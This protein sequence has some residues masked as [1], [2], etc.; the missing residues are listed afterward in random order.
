MGKRLWW[1]C[2]YGKRQLKLRKNI[3][4][5]SLTAGC[6]LLDSTALKSCFILLEFGLACHLGVLLNKPCVGVAKKLF[7]V[8]G[9]EKNEDHHLK[10]EQLTKGGDVFPLVGTTGK[11]LGKVRFYLLF[12]LVT[13]R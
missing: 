6:S 2:S 5:H 4:L 1:P 7:Q 8:D 10:I 12:S 3:F 13:L 11:I 9:L